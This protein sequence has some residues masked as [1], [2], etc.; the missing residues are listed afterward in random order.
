MNRISYLAISLLLA[1]TVSAAPPDCSATQ[2]ISQH[3]QWL[4]SAPSHVVRVTAVSNQNNRLASYAE[5]ALTITGRAFPGTN[6]PTYLGGTLEQ[7]FSDRKYGLAE[8]G[9]IAIPN[10][11]FSPKM[12]DKISLSISSDAAIALTLKSWNNATIKLTDVRCAAG[13]LYGFT[14]NPSGPKS[15]YVIS[16]SKDTSSA[17]VVLK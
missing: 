7:F 11:P 13:V 17:P 9:G 10:H 14:D 6:A 16:L 8:G 2:L 12:T 15:F 4:G 3:V 1:A 5:G